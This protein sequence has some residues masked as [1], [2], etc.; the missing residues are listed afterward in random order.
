[1]HRADG[2]VDALLQVQR[3]SVMPHMIFSAGLNWLHTRY[4]ED[5]GED[6]DVRPEMLADNGEPR[7]LRELEAQLASVSRLAMLAVHSQAFC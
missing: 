2:S 1:M 3:D 7:T 5:G 4:D 6:D